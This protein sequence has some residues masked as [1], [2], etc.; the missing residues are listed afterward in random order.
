[1]ALTK[2][3]SIFTEAVGLV[4]FPRPF[5]IS[6]WNR[7]MMSKRVSSERRMWYRNLSTWNRVQSD[8]GWRLGAPALHSRLLI[9]TSGRKLHSWLRTASFFFFLRFIYLFLAL[10]GLRCC[11]QAFSSCGE[12]GSLSSCGM[13]AFHC[14]GF[15]WGA[16]A[17]GR[18]AVA[19]GLSCHMACGNWTHVPRVGRQT[20]NH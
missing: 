19:H 16:Q 12:Q 3:G 15:S 13:Q 18:V 20:L 2:V 10:P 4:S 5:C 8:Q 1:M 17:L 9:P 7:A 14:D 6:A 11:A